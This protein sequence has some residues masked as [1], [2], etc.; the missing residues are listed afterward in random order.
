MTL[1]IKKK[2]KKSERPR[3]KSP[4][5]LLNTNHPLYSHI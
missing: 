1:F 3:Q 4:I 5:T 2:K